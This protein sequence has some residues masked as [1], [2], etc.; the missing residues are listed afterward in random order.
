MK[1]WN[2]YAAGMLE[3]EL[4]K[5]AVTGTVFFLFVGMVAGML[6][7]WGNG[8]NGSSHVATLSLKSVNSHV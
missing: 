7:S 4:S 5:E 6:L 2:V 3:G 8:K 1:Y